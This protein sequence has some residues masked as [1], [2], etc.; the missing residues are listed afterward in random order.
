MGVQAD[1]VAPAQRRRLAQQFRRHRE[2]RARRQHDLRHRAGPGIVVA[3]D[4][5]LAILQDVVFVLDAGIG[6]QSA[7][8][9]AERHRAARNGEADADLLRRRDLVVDGAAVAEHIGVIEHRRAARQGKFGAADQRGGAAGLGR[10][11]RPQFVVR[12]EPAEEIVVLRRRQRPRQRLVEMVMAIDQSRQDDVAFQIHDRVG[13]RGQRR[14]RTDIAKDA[15]HRVEPAIGQL[16]AL[17]VHRDDERILH[18]QRRQL[19]ILP[20]QSTD[21]PA[22][23]AL[24][25]RPFCCQSGGP[26][27]V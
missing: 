6:R 25:H 22:R 8:R 4:D 1:A 18:Q 23:S 12:L 9:L 7:L 11:R 21:R 5:A 20:G 27:L 15:I 13:G 2:G 26:V 24:M 14:G 10:A 19:P 17:L 16:A 3:A